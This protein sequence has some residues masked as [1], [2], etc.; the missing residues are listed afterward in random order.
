MALFNEAQMTH[1][2][3]EFGMTSASDT[4]NTKHQPQASTSAIMSHL[5]TKTLQRNCFLHRGI[6]HNVKLEL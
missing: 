3:N 5:S 6:C 2:Q 1:A 4:V